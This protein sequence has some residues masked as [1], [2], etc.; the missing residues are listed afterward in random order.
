MLVQSFDEL[1]RPGPVPETVATVIVE[2]VVDGKLAD[3]PALLELLK[4]L[5]AEKRLPESALHISLAPMIEMVED[6][7]IDAPKADV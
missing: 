4:C 5:A 2:Q 6:L 1:P 3:K 7:V